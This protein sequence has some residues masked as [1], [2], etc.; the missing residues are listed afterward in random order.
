MKESG[1]SRVMECVMD[2]TS[3]FAEMYRDAGYDILEY[4]RNK[5]AFDAMLSNVEMILNVPPDKRRWYSTRAKL[6][7]RGDSLQTFGN[8]FKPLKT[9]L[10]EERGYKESSLTSWKKTVITPRRG[11]VKLII[12]DYQNTG[13]LKLFDGR[14]LPSDSRYRVQVFPDSDKITAHTVQFDVLLLV[15]ELGDMFEVNP[16]YSGWNI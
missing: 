9:S 7:P 14:V 3:V 4:Y 16:T 13:G 6:Y 12:T 8:P 15:R 10:L 5:R 1:V 11:E 2:Q